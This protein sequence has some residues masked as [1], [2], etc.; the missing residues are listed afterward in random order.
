MSILGN[1][2]AKKLKMIYFL[3]QNLNLIM[4]ILIYNRVLYISYIL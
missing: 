2:I 3:H 4:K 1:T